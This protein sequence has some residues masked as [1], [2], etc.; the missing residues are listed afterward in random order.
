[1]ISREKREEKKVGSGEVSQEKSSSEIRD[2]KKKNIEGQIWGFISYHCHIN[3][4]TTP[5]FY[6][7]RLRLII[8]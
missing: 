4:S 6:A 7:S 1:M 3:L 5:T 8:N 2:I